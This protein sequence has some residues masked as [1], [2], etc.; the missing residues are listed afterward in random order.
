MWNTTGYSKG[1][2][3]ISAHATTAA[4][5]TDTADNNLTDGWVLIAMMGDV[6]GQGSFPNALPD[7]K[8]DIKDLATMAKCYG[9]TYPSPQYVGNYDLDGN[10]KID[11][12]DL[13]LAA[14]NYG[15]IDP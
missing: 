1:R 7:G 6:A 13:A 5:E 10:G 9:S 4:N 15:K 8:V 3:Q 11:I 12:K 14:K 2:Y